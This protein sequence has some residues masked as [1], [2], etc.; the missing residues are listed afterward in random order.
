MERTQSLS[1]VPI[2]RYIQ[3]NIMIHY[4]Q[5][6]P[7]SKRLI[8]SSANRMKKEL[9]KIRKGLSEEDIKHVNDLFR[10]KE[11]EL[12]GNEKNI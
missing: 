2:S 7:R 3:L 11:K 5:R 4:E 9:D 12:Y 1:D 6:Q 8:Y 10:I